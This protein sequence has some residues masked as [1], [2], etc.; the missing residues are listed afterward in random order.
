MDNLTHS[1]AG[2]L[3]GQMGLKRASRF[4][5]AGCILGANAPDIDVVAPFFL[6]VDNIA[7]HRGPTHALFGLPV[8]AAGTV[9]LLWLLHRLWPGREGIAPFRAGPLFLITLL[10]T[11]THPFLDWLTTY[12]VAFFAPA[13]DGWYSANAIF[14]IDWVYWIIL[15]AGIWLSA[16]RWKQG[17]DHPGRP[18]RVAGAILLAY[19]AANVGWSLHAE[20]SLAAALRQRGIEPR[21]I[22]ASPPP[23]AF[24]ERSLAWRSADRWGAASFSPTGGLA[25][26]PASYP[27]GLDDPRFLRARKERRLVRSFLYWSRM[28]IVVDVAGRPVLTD[29]RY[30]RALSDDRVPAAIRRRAPT[31]QFQIPLDLPSGP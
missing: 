23:L 21:L 16:R 8:M 31:G 30:F 26:E 7:F 14:I 6:P 27:L 12:A 17:W 15:V 3:L 10:A 19:I 18:A 25:L 4:A 9:A 28:P 13:G 2:A 1:L 20:R 5:M 29:Q 22:V 24:W 11:A